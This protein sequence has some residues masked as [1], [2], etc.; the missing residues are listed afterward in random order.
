MV[1]HVEG[2]Y[3]GDT[4]LHRIVVVSLWVDELISFNEFVVI[5]KQQLFFWY[6]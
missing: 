5:S 1:L 6:Y 3:F 2:G 4:V